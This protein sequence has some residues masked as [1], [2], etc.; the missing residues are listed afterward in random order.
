MNNSDDVKKFEQLNADLLNL[1]EDSTPSE[2][3]TTTANIPLT[4]ERKG[5]LSVVWLHVEVVRWFPNYCQQKQKARAWTT[6]SK[7]GGNPVDVGRLN[8][9]MYG[10]WDDGNYTTEETCENCSSVH[11]DTK[12]QSDCPFPVSKDKVYARAQCWDPDIG[13]I[14]VSVG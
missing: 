10:F 1:P 7:E 11:T 6:D 2:R 4:I 9:W 8:I 14:R 3:N 13:P 5:V 12:T